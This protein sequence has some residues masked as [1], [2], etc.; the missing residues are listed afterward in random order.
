LIGLIN[1]GTEGIEAADLWSSE[2]SVCCDVILI[3]TEGM[4]QQIFGPVKPLC[5]VM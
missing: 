4:K 2:A 3:G 1:V 5:D